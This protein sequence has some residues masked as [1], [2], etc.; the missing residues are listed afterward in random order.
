M[1]SRKG[2]KRKH[3]LEII[4]E[5]SRARAQGFLIGSS[6]EV[7][8]LIS[9]C[10]SGCSGFALSHRITNENQ[11]SANAPDQITKSK[12]TKHNNNSSSFAQTTSTTTIVCLS[13]LQTGLC[14][15]SSLPVAALL[16]L[17]FM[18]FSYNFFFIIFCCFTSERLK[19][20]ENLSK[21]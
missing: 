20:R 14:C 15:V 21:K 9:S 6:R 4:V 10:G 11:F 2:G 8:S 12:T 13:T 1:R 17:A 3:S 19:T 18:L 5:R 16:M 7:I